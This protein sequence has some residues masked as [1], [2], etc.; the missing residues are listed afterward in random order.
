MPPGLPPYHQK[1]RRMTVTYATETPNKEAEPATL[2]GN[3][4]RIG[5]PGRAG[6]LWLRKTLVLFRFHAVVVPSGWRIS[7]QPQRWI[8]T[9]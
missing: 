9:W 5:H 2:A 7:V 8:T 3:A 6:G 4:R 1:P